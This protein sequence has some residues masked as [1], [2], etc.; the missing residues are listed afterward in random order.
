M[1]SYM[2]KLWSLKWILI[3]SILFIDALFRKITSIKD[4]N[5]ASVKTVWVGDQIW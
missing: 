1:D 5:C 2:T 4:E 3:K